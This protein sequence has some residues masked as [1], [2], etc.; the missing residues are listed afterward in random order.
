M[1]L[2]SFI[3]TAITL[4]GAL[5]AGQLGQA[6]PP[7]RTA[8]SVQNLPMFSARAVSGRQ[9]ALTV[10]WTVANAPLGT[11][12]AT[13]ALPENNRFEILRRVQITEAPV[14]ERDPQLG[15]DEVVIVALDAQGNEVGWHHLKDP[16]IVRSEQPGPGGLLA[17][18]VLLRA[19]TELAV[20]VPDELTAATLNV[21]EVSWSGSEFVLRSCGTIPLG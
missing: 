11:F 5:L 18:Q 6:L 7:T 17:G 4:S 2:T 16:R 13:P 20:S 1:V 8:A 19:E 12:T 14:R 15:V 21:Y 9:T 3:Q 10:R